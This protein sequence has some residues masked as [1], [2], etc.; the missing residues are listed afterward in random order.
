M[1]NK[2]KFCIVINVN[3]YR[4][5]KL[6]NQVIKLLEKNHIVEI[7]ESQSKGAAKEIFKSLS[8]KIFDRLV[9]TGGDGSFNFAINKI[10][11]YPS[12]LKKDIGYIPTGTANIL[13]IETQVQNR[14]EAIAAVLIAGNTKKINLSK[15]NDC[16]FFLMAGIGFDG[17][18]VNS[19]E[20][21]VKQ[22]L[23]KIIFVIKGS[24]HFLFLNNGKMEVL[25]DNKKIE[26][27]WVLST[28]S[29]YYAGPYKIT[30]LTN[31]FQNGLVT[32]IFSNLTRMKILYYIFLITFYGDLSRAKSIIST[33]SK[34][35]KINKINTNL[36]TQ[37]DGE[38]FNEKEGIE[39]TNTTLF[40]NFLTT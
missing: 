7:F 25:F 39:I 4:N 19:I 15:I 38:L 5:K 18:I 11:Q 8:S 17:K 35:I 34:Y 22:Y 37:I 13:Q 30:K 40:I 10:L 21:S 31:I 16:F 32:Y 20:T 3:A 9:I 36:V 2:I 23:G 1:V 29:Q 33:Q 28:S 27:D 24:Q 6:L 12:L 26:A 14:P